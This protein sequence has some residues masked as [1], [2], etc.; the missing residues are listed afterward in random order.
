[1]SV[2]LPAEQGIAKR[3]KDMMLKVVSKTQG[4]RG[5]N[6]EEEGSEARKRRKEGKGN[7]S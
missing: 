3:V 2:Y 6:R 1:M 7:A 5:N 4:K